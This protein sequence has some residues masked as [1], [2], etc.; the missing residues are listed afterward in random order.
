MAKFYTEETLKEELARKG[1]ER[2][3]I[4]VTVSYFDGKQRR[5]EERE[6]FRFVE[7]NNKDGNNVIN[8]N[9]IIADDQSQKQVNEQNQN[10]NR[11]Y[12]RKKKKVMTSYFDGSK[13]RY[14]E[15]EIMQWV[16]IDEND[17]AVLES[18]VRS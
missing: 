10:T 9:E 11:K 1:L 14:E 2:K 12:V 3:K 16:V 8:R 13:R 17:E 18:V 7:K 6:I 15:R 4:K 5:R